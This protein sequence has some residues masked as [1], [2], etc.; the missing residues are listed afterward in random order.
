MLAMLTCPACLAAVALQGEDVPR[1]A[2]H[3]QWGKVAEAR[4]LAVVER[5][6]GTRQVRLR[7]CRR[8]AMLCG[9]ALCA[10]PVRRVLWAHDGECLSWASLHPA[11]LPPCLLQLRF[12]LVHRLAKA[13]TKPGAMWVG[14][15]KGDA[16]GLYR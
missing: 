1:D 2:T 8:E 5:D 16:D 15:L 14:Q 11:S 4:P 7:G 9:A 12:S 13:S 6:E 10:A 3:T